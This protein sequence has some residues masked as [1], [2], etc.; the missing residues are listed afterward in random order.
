MDQPVATKPPFF[1]LDALRRETDALA[2]KYTGQENALRKALL[3]RLRDLVETARQE[4]RQQLERDGSGPSSA[5]WA[6]PSRRSDASP[7]PQKPRASSHETQLNVK[8]S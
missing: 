5:M 4:A 2:G 7:M 6:P 1:D 3:A 8:P